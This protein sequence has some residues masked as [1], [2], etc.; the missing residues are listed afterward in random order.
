VSSPPAWA[1]VVQL[2]AA[3][4]GWCAV[5]AAGADPAPPGT[6]A[7][8]VPELADEVALELHVVWRRD[9]GAAAEYAACVRERAAAG[10][11]AGGGA[12]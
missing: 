12:R 1:A 9:A 8:R 4:A 10:D 5:V 7:V 11:G 3:G 2:V 6:A